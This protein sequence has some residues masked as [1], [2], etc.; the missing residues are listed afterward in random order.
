MPRLSSSLF[1]VFLLSV[2]MSHGRA[3]PAG[4]PSSFVDQLVHQGLRTLSDV[5]LSA[6]AREQR[7]ASILDSDFD[8]PRIARFVTGSHW[9]GAAASD[10]EHFVNTFKRWVVHTYSSRFSAYG[11]ESVKITGARP[12]SETM[13]TVA[14]QF[15]RTSDAAST[16]LD[17]RVR[18]DNGNDYR[19]VDVA[20]EGV[21]MLLTQ[22][23]EFASVIEHSGGSI[24]GLTRALEEK[25][26][27]GDRSAGAISSN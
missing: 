15:I 1:V 12:E 18:R 25:I 8:F 27:R 13:F 9:S 4:D 22:R 10:R 20:V 24:A 19:V 6:P 14:S 5:Q 26:A 11:G 7:F 23:E 17:W 16:K 21:S 3:A 2:G